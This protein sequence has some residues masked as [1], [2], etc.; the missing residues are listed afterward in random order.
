MASKPPKEDG[1]RWDLPTGVLD[2][3]PLRQL[4]LGKHCVLKLMQGPGAPKEFPITEPETLI[5]RSVAVVADDPGTIDLVVSEA[6][7]APAVG[8]VSQEAAGARAWV[9]FHA[10]RHA[11]RGRRDVGSATIEEPPER[12]T[13]GHE[14]EGYS[15]APWLAARRGDGRGRDAARKEVAGAAARQNAGA[16]SGD[17]W[18][19]R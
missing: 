15:C 14:R 8:H 9:G 1:Y 13:R 6:V 11:L 4:L 5:G 10:V 12:S 3:A 18:L 2:I 19:A 17:D 16:R 7:E